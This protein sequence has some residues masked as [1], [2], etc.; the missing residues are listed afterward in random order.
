MEINSELTPSTLAYQT[1]IAAPV[2]T[3]WTTISSPGILERCH[4]FCKENPV[5]QWP[6]VGAR[7]RIIY[8]SGVVLDRKFL[9]WTENSGY[10]L[11]IGRGNTAAAKVVWTI[12]PES[13]NHCSLKIAI[14]IYPTIALSRYPRLFL[15]L[16]RTFYF[17]PLMRQYVASVVK[18]FKYYV[19]T[20]QV[21]QPNQ[22][23][24]NRLFS[25]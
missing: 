10:E 18:G 9:R 6:G 4:P 8:D 20:G 1:I 24:K 17:L 16:I 2:S 11:V 7:D 5:K 23:G 25:A 19:E 22:F 3:V 21:V 14:S 13:N 12:T 15:P